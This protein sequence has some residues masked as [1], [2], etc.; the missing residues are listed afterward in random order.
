MTKTKKLLS[1]LLSIVLLICAVSPVFAAAE[2]PFD[3]SSF[4]EIGDYS[5]HYRVFKAENQK[6]QIFMIHGFALSSYCFQALAERLQAA[7][8]TCVIADLPDFGYSTRETE[9]TNKLPREDIMH[10]LMV[11]LSDEPWYVAGHS[12]GGYIA[13]ALAQKYPESVKNLLLYGTAGNEGTTS[14]RQKLMSN[15]TFLKVMGKFLEV[16]ARMTA[17]VR[18]LLLA[19]TED[20]QFTKDYDLHYITDPYTVAGTG[21][22]ALINFTMLPETDFT[23]VESMPP[24]LYVHAANDTVI[25]KR[26]V[27]KLSDHLPEGSTEVMMAS[28]GHLFIE[29]RADKTAEITVEFLEAHP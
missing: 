7:G 18:L 25:A 24:I 12:M 9:Q 21:R 29:S 17:L 26:D 15:P 11:S 16:I 14:I 13:I 2:T 20:L 5:I 4:Y 19:A 22:G 10:S 23:A 27:K 3:N 6:G 1:V 8:Y 28:G